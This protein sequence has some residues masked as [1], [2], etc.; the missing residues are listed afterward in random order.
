MP[1]TAPMLNEF[2]SGD[3]SVYVKPKP[4]PQTPLWGGAMVGSV[5]HAAMLSDWVIEQQKKHG[6]GSVQVYVEAQKA[7]WH[8][9]AFADKLDE[10]V[11]KALEERGL[12]PASPSQPVVPQ[13]PIDSGI[14]LDEIIKNMRQEGSE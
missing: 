10:D 6:W 14:S 2:D 1:C 12:I 8:L 7:G 3:Y 5:E 9:E 13:E 11:R 4:T